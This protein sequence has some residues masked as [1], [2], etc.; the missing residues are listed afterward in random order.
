MIVDERWY[1]TPMESSKWITLGVVAILGGGLTCTIASPPPPRGP[2]TWYGQPQTP[3]YA[4]YGGPPPQGGYPPPQGGYPPPQGGYPPPQGGYPPPQ[5]GYPPPQG[6]YPPP[7]GAYSGGPVASTSETIVDERGQSVTLEHGPAGDP[8][9]VGCA[10]GRREGF[11][12]PGRFPQISGCLGA[13]T[14]RQSLRAPPTGKACGDELGPCLVPAD[15]C[16]PGWHVCGASGAVRELRAVS[17]A[18]C[19]QAG[20]GRFAAAI[21]HCKTQSGCAVDDSP[22]AIYDCYPSGWCSEPVCCGRNCGEFGSCR[23][24]VWQDHTH[25]PFGVDQGCASTDARRAGGVLCCRG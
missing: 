16:A 20:G 2:G 7:Q 14:G 23:S 8:A 4:N 13:W 12:D 10:D 9:V 3:A 5:G 11:L 1:F 19:E 25:I 18:D 15:L 6:G 22:G 21:S 17:P 24:G